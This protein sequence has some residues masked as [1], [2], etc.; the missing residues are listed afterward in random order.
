MVTPSLISSWALE[1]HNSNLRIKGQAMLKYEKQISGYFPYIFLKASANVYPSCGERKC[2][3]SIA[4]IISRGRPLFHSYSIL[5]PLSFQYYCFNYIQRKA[6]VPFYTII[7]NQ[8]SSHFSI[9]RTII[10]NLLIGTR[11][12]K[13]IL[14]LQHNIDV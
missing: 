6:C 9:K 7:C 1:M 5:I 13:W 8:S 10:E 12:S 2:A 11:V 14:S 4:S 3:S